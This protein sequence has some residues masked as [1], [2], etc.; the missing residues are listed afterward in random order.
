MSQKIPLDFPKVW[1]YSPEYRGHVIEAISL[2]ETPSSLLCLGLL[3]IVLGIIGMFLFGTF[4]IFI[5]ARLF[6]CLVPLGI[7]FSVIGHRRHKNKFAKVIADVKKQVGVESG[8]LKLKASIR[9]DG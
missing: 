6:G 7:T 8:L 2:R 5:P 9:I 1:P 3:F 4:N